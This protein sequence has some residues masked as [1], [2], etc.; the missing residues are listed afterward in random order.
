MRSR[1]AR[2]LRMTVDLTSLTCTAERRYSTSRDQMVIHK[3]LLRHDRSASVI[4]GREIPVPIRPK[5]LCVTI[6]FFH[7]VR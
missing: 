2:R 3:H 7:A 5:I 1:H 6:A 4:L